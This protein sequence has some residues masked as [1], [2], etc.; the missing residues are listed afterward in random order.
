MKTNRKIWVSLALLL[1][2][3]GGT[4]TTSQNAEARQP[5][6]RYRV[7]PKKAPKN[8]SAYR[9][10]SNGRI[11]PIGNRPIVVDLYADWCGPCKSYK[12]VFNA[13]KARYSHRA[14]FISINTDQR[15]NVSRY[16]R[17]NS[18]PTTLL[19][20]PDGRYVSFSGAVNQPTLENFLNRNL[21]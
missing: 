14:T 18:I 20:Y 2:L 5:N 15:P 13:V 6:G 9:I 11:V 1:G 4:L 19:I 17:V 10:E 7:Q 21:R 8:T 12:P 16:Y 3:M